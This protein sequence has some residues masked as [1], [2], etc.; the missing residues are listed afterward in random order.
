MTTAKPPSA[1]NARFL[2]LIFSDATTPRY[3]WPQAG[4]LIEEPTVQILVIC[5][6]VLIAGNVQ[7]RLGP[8]PVLSVSGACL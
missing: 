2:M 1:R 4:V 6:V 7:G 3:G 8:S 5:A